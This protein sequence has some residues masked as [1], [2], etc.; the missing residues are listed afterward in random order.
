MTG[1]GRIGWMYLDMAIRAAKEYDVSHPYRPTDQESVRIVEDTIN[2]T[3]WGVF[4]V[5]W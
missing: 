1:K 2:E 4:N 5:C 3:L